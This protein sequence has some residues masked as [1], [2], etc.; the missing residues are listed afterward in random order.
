MTPS[1]K[2]GPMAGA[3][4]GAYPPRDK[5]SPPG[6]TRPNRSPVEVAFDRLC[7]NTALGSDAKVIATQLAL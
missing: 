7:M 4:R 3:D 2:P 1:L 6:P 5:H